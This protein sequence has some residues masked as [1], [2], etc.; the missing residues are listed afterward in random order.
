MG[1]EP[2]QTSTRKPGP[3]YVYHT[4]YSLGY[5]TH[6][7]IQGQYKYCRQLGEWARERSGGG[8]LDEKTKERRKKEKAN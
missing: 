3:L 8:G 2:N 7:R 1:K 5:L 6:F 4:Q